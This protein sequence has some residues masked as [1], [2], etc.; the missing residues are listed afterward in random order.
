MKKLILLCLV[1]W[2]CSHPQAL[3][4]PRADRSSPCL[5]KYAVVIE[6]KGKKEL[7]T[8]CKTEMHEFA[9]IWKKDTLIK[10]TSYS[11]ATE[12]ITVFPNVA[13]KNCFFLNLQYGDGCPAMYRILQIKDGKH[14]ISEAFGNCHDEISSYDWKYPTLKIN[15]KESPDFDKPSLKYV[16]DAKKATFTEQRP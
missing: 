14:F 12:I 13:F 4:T 16:F 11:K 15:F 10:E 1:A 2:A 3:K 8:I 7:L 5:D 9:V 6:E